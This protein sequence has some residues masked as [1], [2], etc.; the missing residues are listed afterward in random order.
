MSSNDL[1]SFVFSGDQ[2]SAIYEVARNGS[3]EPEDIDGDETFTL[4][5]GYVVKTETEH[6]QTEYE[7]FVEDSATGYWREIAQG[8]G[9]VDSTLLAEIIS[10][11]VTSTSEDIE[12]EDETDDDHGSTSDDD[13]DLGTHSHGDDDS[14]DGSDDD[15]KYEGDGNANY[16]IG[17][18]GR[19]RL[20]GRD[21][22]DD[23]DG[24]KG[25]DRLFGGAGDDTIKGGD[26]NDIMKGGV[27]DDSL[28]GGDGHERL[29]GNKGKD[30]LFGE[31][32]KD[33]IKGGAGD[34]VLDGGVG[35]DRLFGG[36][37]NDTLTGGEG[38][39]R[40][41]FKE[42]DGDDVITDF[43]VGTD[44]IILKTDFE[45]S[46]ADISLN[47]SGTD[48]ILAYSGGTITLTDVDVVSLTADSFNFG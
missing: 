34:D 41:I 42:Y 29:F 19:D 16:L 32:G 36:K 28:S 48:A 45:E 6:G 10:R 2:V 1:N 9:S 21:G 18:G 12:D 27:G 17:N 38:A 11:S 37:G 4:I 40:F 8:S 20:H 7:I 22:D 39:D 5:D 13:G 23:M 14:Y 30:H 31:E 15:D 25:K 3:L 44:L 46:F 43:E 33:R 24:G 47:Q 26:G 35:D